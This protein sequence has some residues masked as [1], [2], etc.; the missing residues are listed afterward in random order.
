MKYNLYCCQCELQPSS[1]NV[2]R[3]A[4]KSP[5]SCWQV[6]IFI[7]KYPCL[8]TCAGQCFPFYLWRVICNRTVA[9]SSADESLKWCVRYCSRVSGHNSILRTQYLVFYYTKKISVL[10]LHTQFPTFWKYMAHLYSR[11]NQS[12]ITVLQNIRNHSPNTR[13]LIAESSINNFSP[14]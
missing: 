14:E 2:H 7:F 1:I 3:P 12:C 6:D 9:I 13:C 8:R 11:V 10:L 4:L 5:C